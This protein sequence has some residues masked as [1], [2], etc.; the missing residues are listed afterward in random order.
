M[1]G[2]Y[3]IL[4]SEVYDLDKP[5]GHSFGDVEYYA[6]RLK[7]C[8]GPILEPATGTGRILIPLLEQGFQVEG[9]DISTEMLEHCKRNCAEK[10]L[11][12]K[13]SIERM[14]AFKTDT[15]YE[16]IIIPTG[17]FLLLHE[18]ESSIRALQNF[19]EHLQDGGR[20][21]VDLLFE[22]DMELGKVSERF[23]ESPAGDVLT[24][25]HR[26]VKND[27]IHQYSVAHNRYERWRNGK[28]V[29]SELERMPIR[30][31][32]IEEFKEILEKIGFADISVSA[33][34]QYGRRPTHGNQLLSFEAVANK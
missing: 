33:D 18:R 34:Y 16:A 21:I 32:G 23:W 14:E 4:S 10:G 26:K 29:E 19:Y 2:Y 31:Y 1:F 20:L 11:A 9:F 5:I 17:T 28:L 12:P 27:W 25:E 7:G 30:W 13:L 8:K 22:T 24:V 15:R 3:S 6:E